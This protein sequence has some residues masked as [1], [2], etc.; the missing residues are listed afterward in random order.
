MEYMDSLWKA[1]TR[2][3]E[4]Y[5][6]AASFRR[7]PGTS[8]ASLRKTTGHGSP[9]DAVGRALLRK[10][11]PRAQEERPVPKN[12]S[13]PSASASEQLGRAGIRRPED[14]VVQE[15]CVWLLKRHPQVLQGW[16]GCPGAHLEKSLLE[17]VFWLKNYS[18]KLVFVI[19]EPEWGPFA[20]MED[21]RD[22][23]VSWSWDETQPS[24]QVS[25]PSTISDVMNLFLKRFC[26][27]TFYY[28]FH[29]FWIKCKQNAWSDLEKSWE[30]TLSP[31]PPP[32]DKLLSNEWLILG[33]LNVLNATVPCKELST[34]SFF[35]IWAFDWERPLHQGIIFC[36]INDWF[37]VIWPWEIHHH[38]L[39]NS[40]PCGFW[41]TAFD[42][43]CPHAWGWFFVN[44]WLI[45]G[46]SNVLNAS[47]PFTVCMILT[48]WGIA[49][50][51]VWSWGITKSDLA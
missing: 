1:W 41:D 11:R 23:V 32:G 19:A 20:W 10:E 36:Q 46:D 5:N 22:G 21:W 25:Y 31:R 8:P 24:S 17:I 29:R 35:E 49:L 12:R 7:Q 45:L 14:E 44:N 42:L 13:I 37:W 48:S 28:R 34:P 38:H 30:I 39:K 40:L 4:F 16:Q 47:Q 50:S 18:R 51:P 43:E 6:F 26:R 2:V 9:V 33:H 27:I 3:R 15:F